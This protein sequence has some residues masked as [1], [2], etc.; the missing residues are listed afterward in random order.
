MNALWNHNL[1]PVFPL[2]LNADRRR[3]PDDIV[4]RAHVRLANKSIR[5]HEEGQQIVED[6]IK[7][8]KRGKWERHI[9]SSC[10]AVTGRSSFLDSSGEL[11]TAG[12]ALDPEFKI[13]PRDWVKLIKSGQKYEWVGDGVFATLS[14]GFDDDTRGITYNL[15]VIFEDHV[16]KIKIDLENEQRRRAEGDEKGWNTTAKAEERAMQ[17][18]EIV[19][20]LEEIAVKRGDARITR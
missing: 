16:T 12:C 14:V 6:I 4:S 2:V 20:R 13:D 5:N 3:T 7:Q 18:A 17:R 1:I 19:K 11:N 10:P 15:V 8:F 9:S